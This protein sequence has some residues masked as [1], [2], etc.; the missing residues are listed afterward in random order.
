MVG[1]A[2]MAKQNFR[3]DDTL[4]GRGHHFLLFLLCQNRPII[5]GGRVREAFALLHPLASRSP[6]YS[7][8]KSFGFDL[9]SEHIRV[10]KKLDR[11]K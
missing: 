7:P 8:N 6:F 5:T 10:I 4:G 3:T 1:V 9:A 11:G 2:L